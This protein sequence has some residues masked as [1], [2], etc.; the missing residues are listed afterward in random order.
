MRSSKLVKKKCFGY[1]S[2][3]EGVLCQI[4]FLIAVAR[5]FILIKISHLTC[6]GL[7]AGVVLSAT[8]RIKVFVG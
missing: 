4:T 2:L 3:I 8:L 6:E 7:M 5:P 1:V